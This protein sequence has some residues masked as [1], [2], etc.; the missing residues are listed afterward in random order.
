MDWSEKTQL[1][2]GNSGYPTVLAR[3]GSEKPLGDADNQQE[4]NWNWILTAAIFIAEVWASSCAVVLPL[5]DEAA[6]ARS[7]ARRAVQTAKARAQVA[8][9]AP[10]LPPVHPQ[11]LY[12][13]RHNPEVSKHS[14]VASRLLLWRRYSLTSMA[15]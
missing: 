3:K 1:Y 13:E 14:D 10:S 5:A 11:R 2:A 15:T 8:R 4:R 6:R 9:S 7:A 12:V